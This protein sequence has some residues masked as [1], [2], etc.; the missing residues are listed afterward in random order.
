MEY[1][2]CNAEAGHVIDIEAIGYFPQVDEG[3]LHSAG[4]QWQQAEEETETSQKRDQEAR[5]NVREVVGKA[6]IVGKDGS[7][8]GAHTEQAGEEESQRKGLAR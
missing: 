5:R 6:E 4:G 1:M 7:L 2:L 3:L 8:R